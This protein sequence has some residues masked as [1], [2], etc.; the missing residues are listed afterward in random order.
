MQEFVQ[1]MRNIGQPLVRNVVDKTYEKIRKQGAK[2]F[3]GI[4]D[5]VVVEE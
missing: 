4:T 2:A 1:M 5:P 3:A